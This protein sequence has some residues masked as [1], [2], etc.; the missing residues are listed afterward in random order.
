MLVGLVIMI[1]GALLFVPSAYS[2]NY[3]YFLGDLFVLETGLTILQT[4]TNPYVIFLG[5]KESAAKRIAIMELINKVADVAVPIVFRHL[6]YQ[7]LLMF[8][9]LRLW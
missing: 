8:L 4:A 7:M 1:I 5:P 2:I 3:L 6:F 9:N